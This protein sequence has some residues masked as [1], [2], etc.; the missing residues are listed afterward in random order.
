MYCNKS[1]TKNTFQ[2]EMIDETNNREYKVAVYSPKISVLR[3]FENLDD[4]SSVLEVTKLIAS[5][6]SNNS[7]KIKFSSEIIEDI[8]S[9]DDMMDFLDDYFTWV[10]EVRKN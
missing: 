5:I 10:S 9:I 7:E 3:R 6:I 4:D 1:K 8:F 2:L